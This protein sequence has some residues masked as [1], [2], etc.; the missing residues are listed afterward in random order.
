MSNDLDRVVDFWIF[1]RCGDR[2]GIGIGDGLVCEE[3]WMKFSLTFDQ[4]QCADALS[5]AL[6][7]ALQG[8]IE[9]L[10]IVVCMNDGVA[11]VMCGKN[12]GGLLL[13][14]TQLIHN[15]RSEVFERGNLATKAVKKPV[16]LR[17]R[18]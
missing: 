12:A 3:A 4:Q 6:E 11:P 10:A 2:C 13:G 1:H 7:L 9:S 16:I 18:P 15:I 8:K 5:D 14:A 17:A